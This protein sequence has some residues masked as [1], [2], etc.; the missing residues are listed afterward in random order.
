[1]P[2]ALPPEGAATSLLLELQVIVVDIVSPWAVFATAVGV[3]VSPTFVVGALRVTEMLATVLGG[4]GGGEGGFGPVALPPSPPPEQAI[5]TQA[6]AMMIIR[7]CVRC[8][9]S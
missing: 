9:A 8:P 4:S 2:V 5:S 1:M 3:A 6:R 7:G